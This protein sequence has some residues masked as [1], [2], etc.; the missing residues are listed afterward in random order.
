M[1]TM[2][3]IVRIECLA[4]AE[5]LTYGEYMKR[6]G[7]PFPRPKE[8]QIAENERICKKCGRVFERELLKNGNLSERVNCPKCIAE[9]RDIREKKQ[10][11]SI[12][13]GG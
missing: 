10:R 3:Q 1:T 5:G 7:E 4:R 12:E 6:H 9:N 2:Q 11:N 13:N 8:P